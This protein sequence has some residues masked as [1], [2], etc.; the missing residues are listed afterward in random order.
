M[1]PHQLLT[2]YQTSWMSKMNSIEEESSFEVLETF[3]CTSTK[4][5]NLRAQ[6][7]AERKRRMD[8]E[9]T[10]NRLVGSNIKAVTDLLFSAAQQGHLG[11]VKSLL[12]LLSDK[13]PGDNNGWTLLHY[14]ARN[15]HLDIVKYLCGQVQDKNPKDNDGW[16]PLHSAA[17]NGNLDIV[18]YLCAQLEDK[19]PKDGSGWTPLHFAACNGKTEI[20]KYFVTI[21]DD[22]HPKSDYGETPSYVSNNTEII[23]ILGKY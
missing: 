20:V 9:E 1:M 15:G 6:F 13:N 8:L 14:A 10:M 12:P 16:T 18:K 2:N 7:K 4:H 11:T 23:N 5:Y 21:V 22:K 19:N 3:D 17:T